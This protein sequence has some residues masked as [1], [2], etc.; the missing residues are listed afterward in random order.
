M[1]TQHRG[2]AGCGYMAENKN[3]HC[4]QALMTFSSWGWKQEVKQ[5]NSWDSDQELHAAG[6][7]LSPVAFLRFLFTL[8]NFSL[9]DGGSD[10]EFR[11]EHELMQAS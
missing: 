4:E 9:K 6:F 1:L 5:C 10:S 2:F 8:L 7:H 11:Q 3:Y